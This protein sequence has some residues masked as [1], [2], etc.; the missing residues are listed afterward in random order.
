MSNTGVF[1]NPINIPIIDKL[2]HRDYV[3]IVAENI[4]CPSRVRQPA[5]KNWE[6]VESI[7]TV[8]N[9]ISNQNSPLGRRMVS[10]IKDFI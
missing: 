9:E 10:C 1:Q 6:T 7:S 4:L 5:A 3:A 8:V 2:I